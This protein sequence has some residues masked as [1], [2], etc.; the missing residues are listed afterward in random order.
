MI[1][2][3]FRAS[4]ATFVIS[5]G[6]IQVAAINTPLFDHDPVTLVPKSLLI[7]VDV[8]SVIPRSNAFSAWTP[9]GVTFTWSSDFPIF[10][11]ESVW[12]ITTNGT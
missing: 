12:L 6:L 4:V 1:P 7:E 11:S 9:T 8:M 2:S 3:L 10:A 5:R